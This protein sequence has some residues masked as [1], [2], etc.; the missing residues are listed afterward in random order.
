MPSSDFQIY[1]T[2]GQIKFGSTTLA[3][4]DGIIYFSSSASCAKTVF[5]TTFNRWETTIPL[6][7]AGN[8]GG[9]FAAGLAYQI[10]SGFGGTSSITWTAEIGR[11]SCRERAKIS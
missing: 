8:A 5:N 3:V 9:Y 1:I 7:Q 6:S 4:P 2:N 10:P 11:A